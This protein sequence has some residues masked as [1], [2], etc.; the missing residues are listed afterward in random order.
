[1]NI[2][3]RKLVVVAVVVV[4]LFLGGCAHYIKPKVGAVAQ[5]DFI[6]MFDT[7]KVEP[8]SIKTDDLQL[9]YSVVKAGQDVEVKAEA[10]FGKV[11]TNTHNRAL[12]FNL[13]LSFVDSQRRVISAVDITPMFSVAATIPD[14]GKFEVKGP[15]PQGSVGIVLNY[16]GVFGGDQGSR[17][18]YELFHF[19]FE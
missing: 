8:Y 7:L 12:K 6:V 10:I 2:L 15:A 14:K 11:L 19:P 1:M 16:Y 18:T 9:N 5:E 17:D 4:G 13:V 3:M